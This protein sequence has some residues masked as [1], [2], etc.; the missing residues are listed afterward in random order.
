MKL[1]TPVQTVNASIAVTLLVSR[2]AIPLLD[3]DLE[4]LSNVRLK[5]ENRLGSKGMRNNLSLARMF[6][7][8]ACVEKTTTDR[9]EG[10]IKVAAPCQFFPSMPA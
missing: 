10:I 6:S 5:L 7:S 8:V 3:K 2:D 4:V 1:L 9:H